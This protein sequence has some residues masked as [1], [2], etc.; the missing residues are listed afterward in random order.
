MEAIKASYP[1]PSKAPEAIREALE[2]TRVVSSKQI[3]TDLHKAAAAI[4][5]S[6]KMVQELQ[7]QSLRHRQMWVKHLQEALVAWQQQ[8]QS[9]NTAQ[10][11][12]A[13]E[14][15]KAKA[16][17]QVANDWIQELN[18]RA[19]ELDLTPIE[20][21]AEL[22]EV[23]E[24]TELHPTKVQEQLQ[25]K[26]EECIRMA[27]SKTI[28]EVDLTAEEPVPEQERKRARSQDTEAEAFPTAKDA[29]MPSGS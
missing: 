21:T 7:E 8:I 10:K 2:R 29:A 19:K 26:L 25:K 13:T 5:K 4:G 28:E 24:P 1:D 6:R 9:Y 11:D 20:Q 15:A 14:L 18:V 16:D 22:G 23:A 17:L 12:F 3:T 27:T